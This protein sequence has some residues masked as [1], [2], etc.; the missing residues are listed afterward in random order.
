MIDTTTE[1]LALTWLRS[2]HPQLTGIIQQHWLDVVACDLI[3]HGRAT[4]TFDGQFVRREAPQ[5]VP[6]TRAIRRVK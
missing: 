6:R 2:L 4:L 1:D 5:A 3:V